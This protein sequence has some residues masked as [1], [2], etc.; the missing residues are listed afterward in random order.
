MNELS[1]YK[2]IIMNPNKTPDTYL[3]YIK[4]R[5]PNNYKLK[6]FNTEK[7]KLFPLTRAVGIGSKYNSYFVH[8][9]PKKIN[10]KNKSLY[11][12]GKAITFDTGGINLKT[13]DFSDM[14]IDMTGSALLI[15]VLN[16]LS[17]N[18]IDKNYNIHIIMSIAENMIGNTATKPG[19]V[20][21]SM[22]NI[23]IEIINSDAEG[24]LCLVDGIEYVNKFLIK[25]TNALIL[26][27]ATL[28]GNKDQITSTIS[29]LT[30][31]NDKGSIYI[32]K[33]FSIGETIGEYIDYLKIRPE[34][35]KSLK[36]QV[37]DIKNISQT[38]RA[39]CIMAGTFLSYFINNNIPWIH[40]D[41]GGIVYINSIINSYGINLLYEF[42]KAL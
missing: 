25:N 32:N 24:R 28:T 4:S 36:S 2:N 6:Y 17:F 13:G 34:Y 1:I 21:K 39:D 41:L 33:L 42:I 27:I 38:V 15:S 3:K 18:K 10:N 20:I 23:N 40:I 30:T 11:L 5:I 29:S 9:K 35:L 8:I 12:I 19:T 22:N 16:L 14:K 37:A 26:D 7:T 31:A